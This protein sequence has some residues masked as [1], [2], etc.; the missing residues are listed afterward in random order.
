MSC[1]AKINNKKRM[2]ERVPGV[3]K[4]EAAETQDGY[5]VLRFGDDQFKNPCICCLGRSSFH[6]MMQAIYWGTS[7]IKGYYLRRLLNNEDSVLLESLL[8]DDFIQPFARSR[9]WLSRCIAQWRDRHNADRVRYGQ[10][11]FHGIF[12]KLPSQHVPRPSSWASRIR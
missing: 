10:Q 7:G 2:K 6:H 12:L 8:T 3:T 4:V 1:P 11:L 5:I 9:F